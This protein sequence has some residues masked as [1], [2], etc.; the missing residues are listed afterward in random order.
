MMDFGNKEKG[1]YGKNKKASE[2]KK[3]K[4][5]SE[6]AQMVHLNTESY[7]Q[8]NITKPKENHFMVKAILSVWKR[9]KN[10]FAIWK[11]KNQA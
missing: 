8:M 4:A 7:I 6:N 9:Q 1:N 3:A 5:L 10:S 2:K 11:R